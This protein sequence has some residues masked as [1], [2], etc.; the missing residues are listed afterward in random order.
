MD[1]KH[2]SQLPDLSLDEIKLAR[3][4]QALEQNYYNRTVTARV[5]GVSVRTIAGAIQRFKGMGIEIPKNPRPIHT[6]A[7]TERVFSA[8]P[9]HE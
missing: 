5:L 3:I 1:I 7:F 4:Y 9:E 8:I 6:E 2:I